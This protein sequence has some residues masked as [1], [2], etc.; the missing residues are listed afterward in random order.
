MIP[1]L[2]TIGQRRSPPKGRQ[3]KGLRVRSGACGDRRRVLYAREDLLVSSVEWKSRR[4]GL[5][6]L[7]SR[8]ASGSVSIRLAMSTFATGCADPRGIEP[9]DPHGARARVVSLY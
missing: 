4:L 7:S 5:A 3:E 1:S 6:I 2:A 9:A 8:A